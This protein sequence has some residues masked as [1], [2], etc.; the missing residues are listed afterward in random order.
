M[1]KLKKKKKNCNI[2]IYA[3]TEYIN[4]FVLAAKQNRKAHQNDRLST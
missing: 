3:H 1:F 2:A 4:S